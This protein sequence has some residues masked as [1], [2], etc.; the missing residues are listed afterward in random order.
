[1]STA[2][3]NTRLKRYCQFMAIITLIPLFSAMIACFS[4]LLF[5]FFCMNN[6]GLDSDGYSL[7]VS[8]TI[9]VNPTTLVFWQ[10]ALA[11]LLDTLP[12]VAL[13]YG[14]Y[15]LRLLFVSYSQMQYFSIKSS[16]YCYNFGKALV[17]WVVLGFIFEPL[18]SIITTF[19][20]DRFISVSLTSDDLITLF[21]ALSIMIIGHVLKQASQIA[22]ENEQFV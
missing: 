9:N 13:T 6:I 12:I 8:T 4:P 22:A 15:Q 14:F 16:N 2:T 5:Y 10:T 7:F 21:P 17:A 3:I 18:L 19:Y 20:S 11:T 1:M